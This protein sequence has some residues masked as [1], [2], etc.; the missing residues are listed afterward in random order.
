VEFEG[1]GM[2]VFGP[3]Y[4]TGMLNRVLVRNAY[5]T[6]LHCAIQFITALRITSFNSTFTSSSCVEFSLLD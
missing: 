5:C 3:K 1:E 4:A 2:K 6:L